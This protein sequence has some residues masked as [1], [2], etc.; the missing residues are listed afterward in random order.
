MIDPVSILPM[1]SS[2]LSKCDIVVFKASRYNYWSVNNS[3]DRCE[4]PLDYITHEIINVQGT[5]YILLFITT[6]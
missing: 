6:N 4:S 5:H 3:A 1:N 2:L